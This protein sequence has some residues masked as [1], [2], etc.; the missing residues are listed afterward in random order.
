M[1]GGDGGT[2]ARVEHAGVAIGE[3]QRQLRRAQARENPH[4]AAQGGVMR[5]LLHQDRLV[6]GQGGKIVAR[7][8]RGIGR[9]DRLGGMALER[10]RKPRCGAVG[11]VGGMGHAGA[12]TGGRRERHQDMPHRQASHCAASRRGQACPAAAKIP[13]FKITLPP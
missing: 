1:V 5:R 12:Q 8:D 3:F 13:C 7:R 9:R 11:R 6:L 10:L 2:L 4:L